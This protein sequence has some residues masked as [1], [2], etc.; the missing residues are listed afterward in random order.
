MSGRYLVK[1]NAKANAMLI[2]MKGS[3]LVKFN[4]NGVV[5]SYSVKW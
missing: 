2:E 4:A 5:G 1:F 3:Y